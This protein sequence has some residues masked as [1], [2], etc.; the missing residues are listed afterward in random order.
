MQNLHLLL[1]LQI[2]RHQTNWGRQPRQPWT[3]FQ[4][5]LFLKH[6]PWTTSHQLRGGLSVKRLRRGRI[7]RGSGPK[8]YIFFWKLRIF[9]QVRYNE[10]KYY[11]LKVYWHF[12]LAFIPTKKKGIF[13]CK[14]QHMS[15]IQMGQGREVKHEHK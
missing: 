3:Y 12:S 7:L 4:T 11:S 1:I 13:K 10:Y 15:V 8:L 9:F 14:K 6:L 2:S 5:L